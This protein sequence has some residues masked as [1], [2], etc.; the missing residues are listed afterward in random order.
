MDELIAFDKHAYV[1]DA[2]SGGVEEQQIARAKLGNVDRRAGPPLLSG[3]AGKS[4]M[5]YL[6]MQGLGEP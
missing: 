4:T 2:L 3:R 1:R 6:G 5:T